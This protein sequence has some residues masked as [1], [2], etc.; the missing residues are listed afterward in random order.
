MYIYT[1]TGTTDLPTLLAYEFS[2]NVQLIVF[3]AFFAS[4]AVK[5]PS[6]PFHI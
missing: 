3:L 2:D 6:F 4:L 5:L 1:L